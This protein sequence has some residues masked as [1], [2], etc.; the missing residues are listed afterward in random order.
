[1]STLE[2]IPGIG[3]ALRRGLDSLGITDA[4]AL[5][6]ADVATITQV[7]GISPAR[8]ETFIASAKRLAAAADPEQAA[9]ETETVKPTNPDKK[10]KAADKSKGTKKKASKSKTKEKKSGKDKSGKS[11]KARKAKPSKKKKGKTKKD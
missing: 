4:A 8:A 11:G 5:A 6:K 10:S 1:M 3:P 9:R 2:N 7:R